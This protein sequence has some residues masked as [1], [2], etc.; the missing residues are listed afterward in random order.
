MPS[1]GVVSLLAV[2]FARIVVPAETRVGEGF[3]AADIA[4]LPE[5]VAEEIVVP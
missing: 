1:L 4:W 5:H 2:H 3:A